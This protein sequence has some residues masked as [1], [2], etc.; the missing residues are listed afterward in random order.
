MNNKFK[1]TLV[2]LAVALLVTGAA[3]LAFMK[4]VNIMR[5]GL[6][7]NYP[8]VKYVVAGASTEIDSVLQLQIRESEHTALYQA[9]CNACNTSEM[10]ITLPYYARYEIGLNSRYFRIIRDKNTVE[11]WL[12]DPALVFCDIK[13]DQM[14]VNG[15]PVS[16]N[17]YPA[18]KQELYKTILPVLEKNKS[19]LHAARQNV[20]KALIYYFVPYK[21]DLKLYINNEQ[22]SLPEVPGVTIDVDTYLKRTFSAE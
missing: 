2:L 16:Y 6:V 7:A 20:A 12:P 17:K 14:K 4:G 19:H 1:I 21:L 10:Q 9:L 8:V 5:D 3:Y 22:Q 13:I 11:V 15:V 18:L